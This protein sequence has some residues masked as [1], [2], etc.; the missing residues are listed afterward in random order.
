[1]IT[2]RPYRKKVDVKSAVSE[3]QKNSGTQF[4]P[5][6]INVFS[7]VIKDEEINRLLQKGL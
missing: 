1:M 2:R 7:E 3:I 6:A 4:D 5:R